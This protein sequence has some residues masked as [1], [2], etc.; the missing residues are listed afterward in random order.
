MSRYRPGDQVL[1]RDDLELGGHYKSDGEEKA[2]CAFVSP[3]CDYCGKIVT[4][5]SENGLRDRTRYRIA[6]DGGDW[7]WTDEMFVG[8]ADESGWVFDP[9]DELFSD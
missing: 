9:G 1:V 7:A 3:M 4:I 5:V 8:L 6:E 2:R